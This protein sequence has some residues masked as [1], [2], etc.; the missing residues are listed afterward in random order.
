MIDFRSLTDSAEDIATLTDFYTTL[1]TSEFP[2][3]DERESLPNMIDYLERKA[4]GWY[5]RNNYHIL[6]AWLDDRLVGGSVVDYLAEPNV[7]VIEFLFVAP[8]ARQSGIGRQV[9]TR[10]EQLL[11]QDARR[12]TGREL[13]A[14]VAEMN[15]PL[16]PSNVR[17]NLDPTARALIWHR[18]GYAGL[19]FPYV[20]PPLAEDTAAVTNLIVIAKPL[21]PDW[22]AAL[23]ST[24]VLR[25]VHEYL[26]WAIRIDK[27]SDSAD[28][29][30]MAAHLDRCDAVRI[31][32]L[33]AYVGRDP[34]RPLHI[35]EITGPDDAD[36]AL[37]MRRYWA[38]FG[39][40]GLAVAEADFQQA[41][42][43]GGS[44]HLWSLRS[45]EGGPV[46]GLA[47]FRTLST[48]GFAGY[49]VLADALRHTGRLRALVARIEEQM[50]R[51][52]PTVHGW[53]IE[54]GADTDSGPFRSVGFHQ[55]AVDYQQPAVDEP[56][57][58]EQ[59]I[60]VR[61]L[62]K[63]VGR[64][65]QAPRLA[66]HDVLTAV[67]EILAQVY[68]VAEPREHP[69]FTLLA[70]DLANRTDPVNLV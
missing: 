23:P 44:Y 29:R 40:S 41:L 16:A 30:R 39:N 27:P 6:L 12:L 50:L 35:R 63:Q 47:S 1:Y 64:C 34:D 32:P 22:S 26:R 68:D 17:D 31:V 45:A 60:P 61:L 53:Y 7:G 51:D 14:V 3:P 18:W 2:D 15:D 10:T 69:A 59:T 67:A 8:D 38:A 13:D 57:G 46:D 62:Y 9:L 55:L 56:A 24:T 65:Y 19:D 4:R 48:A 43:E 54:V 25:F 21:R 20:Q 33:A 52:Q 28:Y 66:A 37:T 11:A 49:L 70:Q 36:F 5:G 42:A 58:A